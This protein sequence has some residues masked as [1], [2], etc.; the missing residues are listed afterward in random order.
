MSEDDSEIVE[1]TRLK[2]NQIHNFLRIFLCEIKIYIFSKILFS[3]LF[4]EM[5]ESDEF[6]V[7]KYGVH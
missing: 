4:L 1:L 5:I 3:F 6:V 7:E 2:T